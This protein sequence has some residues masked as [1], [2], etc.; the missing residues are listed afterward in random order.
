MPLVALCNREE[1]VDLLKS[2]ETSIV[3]RATARELLVRKPPMPNEGG[4][5][6]H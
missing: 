3:L 5:T 6:L 1:L 2:T 4:H